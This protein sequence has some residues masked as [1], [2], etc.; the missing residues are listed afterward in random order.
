MDIYIYIDAYACPYI[1][2]TYAPPLVFRVEAANALR[3]QL[4]T[5]K[6]ALSFAGEISISIHVCI[7]LEIYV[8]INTYMYAYDIYISYVYIYVFIH[9]C[10]DRVEAANALPSQLATLK[11]ALSFAGDILISIYV[12]ICICI[13][14]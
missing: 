5:L 7:L 3:S 1:E 14:R 13:Y 6:K 12:C 9:I 11:R 8:D 2:E 4:A 10:I